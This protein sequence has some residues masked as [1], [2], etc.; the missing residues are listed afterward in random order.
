MRLVSNK[1]V[2]LLKDGDAEAFEKIFM[3]YRDI[4]YYECIRRL[5]NVS[6]ANDCVQ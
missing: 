3:A 6:D 2:E 5:R 1:V 4:V